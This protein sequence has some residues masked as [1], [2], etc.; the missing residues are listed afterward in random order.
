MYILSRVATITT[1]YTHISLGD[2][3]LFTTCSDVLQWQQHCFSSMQA[4]RLLGYVPFYSVEQGVKLSWVRWQDV[5][6]HR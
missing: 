3:D 6:G 4:R 5:N 2:L 1:R